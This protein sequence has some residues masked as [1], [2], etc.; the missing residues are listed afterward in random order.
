[1]TKSNLL[2]AKLIE[3]NITLKE[4]AKIL[5]LSYP[6]TQ[7]KVSGQA[8]FTQTELAI[9][10]DVLDLTLQEFKIMFLD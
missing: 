7:K 2:R 9:L 5:G 8:Q 4:L 3:K 6:Q 1:M 10:K